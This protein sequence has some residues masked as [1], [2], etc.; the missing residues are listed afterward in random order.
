MRILIFSVCIDK[1]KINAGSN[2]NRL[3]SI[4]YRS[5]K[6]KKRGYLNHKKYF[7]ETMLNEIYNFFHFRNIHL[8]EFVYQFIQY[9]YLLKFKDFNF[10]ICF[11]CIFL[12]LHKVKRKAKNDNCFFNSWIIVIWKYLAKYFNIK[13]LKWNCIF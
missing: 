13:C 1:P 5:I 12:H 6:W 7:I 9:F 8:F 3:S 2:A 4:G 11:I 10:G